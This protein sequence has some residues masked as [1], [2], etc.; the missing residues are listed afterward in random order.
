MDTQHDG[1]E[2]LTPFKHS[3]FW[4]IYIYVATKKRNFCRF[5][6]GM[7]WWHCG[8]RDAKVAFLSVVASLFS[9]LMI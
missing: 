1:L 4:Y 6:P 5:I 9:Y 3:N 8:D 2:K 7:H